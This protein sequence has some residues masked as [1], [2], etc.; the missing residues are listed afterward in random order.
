MHYHNPIL[1]ENAFIS[2]ILKASWFFCERPIKVV[3]CKKMLSFGKHPQLINIVI[4][5]IY[6]IHLQVHTP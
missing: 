5:G 2:G 6:Y 4:K 3:N 1:L